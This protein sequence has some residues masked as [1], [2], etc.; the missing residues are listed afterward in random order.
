MPSC[1]GHKLRAAG[2]LLCLSGCGTPPP[3]ISAA[4]GWESVDRPSPGFETRWTHDEKLWA[5]NH[6]DKVTKFCGLAF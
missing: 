3:A 4:C 1:A 5:V 6:N 2:L